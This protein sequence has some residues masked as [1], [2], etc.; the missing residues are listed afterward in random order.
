MNLIGRNRILNRALSLVIFNVSRFFLKTEKYLPQS[1]PFIHAASSR[2]Q[3]VAPRNN[4][5]YFARLAI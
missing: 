4:M 2:V 1:D 5:R 3:N